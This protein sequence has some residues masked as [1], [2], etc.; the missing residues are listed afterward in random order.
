[1]ASIHKLLAD[2]QAAFAML[3][4]AETPSGMVVRPQQ[5]EALHRLARLQLLLAIEARNLAEALVGRGLTWE[6]IAK[7]AGL[8]SAGE[9]QGRWSPK[10][11]AEVS[12]QSR[13]RRN[14]ETTKKPGA[15]TAKKT[16]PGFKPADLPGV[17]VPDAAR[18][19]GVSTSTIYARVAR[20][21][22]DVVEISKIHT[23]GA[24]VRVTDEHVLRRASTLDT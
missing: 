3:E 12:R 19:L 11:A 21:E 14:S 6:Q 22:L 16:R 23:E 20:G 4:P 7:L 2:A 10:Q 1:M 17:S 8:E 18:I 9:A 24:W 13:A 15:R 5:Q